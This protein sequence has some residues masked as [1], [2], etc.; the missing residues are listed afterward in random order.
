MYCQL[1]QDNC[2]IS[3]IHCVIDCEESGKLLQNIKDNCPLL[4]T[5]DVIDI[6]REEKLWN[7]RQ[8]EEGNQD[9]SFTDQNDEDNYFVDG[10]DFDT[11]DPEEIA[12]C[13]IRSLD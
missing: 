3:Y 13:H 1:L 7:Q 8:E 12:S 9:N 2:C 10:L 4:Q 11:F 5:L 6:S